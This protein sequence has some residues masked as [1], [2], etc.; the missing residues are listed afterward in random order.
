M[1]SLCNRC[2]RSS[3]KCSWLKSGKMSGARSTFGNP[4]WTSAAMDLPQVGSHCALP[5][6]NVL[7]FLP[8]TCQCKKKY[9]FEHISSE[10]HDCSSMNVQHDMSTFADKILRCFVQG[11]NKP[12]L[13]IYNGG[14]D[15][16]CSFCHKSLCPEY[17]FRQKHSLNTNDPH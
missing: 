12:S 15:E 9:C 3:Q 5:S 7:D 13:R 17:V 11:C 14:P 4:F 2:K 1:N 6:C 10:R 16:T 8:I